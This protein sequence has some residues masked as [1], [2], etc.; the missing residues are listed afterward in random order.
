MPQ[1]NL[2]IGTGRLPVTPSYLTW[3]DPVNDPPTSL[4]TMT[5]DAILSEEHDRSTVV[6]DHPVEQGTNIVDNVRPLP[7]KLT[8]EVFVSNSPIASPDAAQLPV[9]LELPMPS[10][11][12]FLAGGTGAIISNLLGGGVP[13]PTIGAN[14]Q[15]FIGE[16]DYVSQAYATLTQLQSTATLLAAVTPR[17]AYSNMVLESVRMHRNPGTGTSATFTLEMRE[18]IIIYSGIV[19][20]PLPSIPRAAPPVAAGK[21]QTAPADAPKVS[22]A[23]LDANKQGILKVGSGL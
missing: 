15:Q 5:F 23:K 17:A 10:Q 2:E 4:G 18:V 3:G 9:T 19:A 7:D 6:T 11:G 1:T 12:S 21:Q 13:G 14:V 8:L 20:A 22:L 16:T